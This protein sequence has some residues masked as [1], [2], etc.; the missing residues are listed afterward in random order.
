MP[1][2][3]I[4]DACNPSGR[5]ALELVAVSQAST[6]VR[7]IE[8]AGGGGVTLLRAQSSILPHMTILE[9]SFDDTAALA[10]CISNCSVVFACTPADMA[11]VIEALEYCQTETKRMQ[12]TTRLV[13]SLPDME[14]AMRELTR[15]PE[16]LSYCHFAD[17]GAEMIE[18][19]SI[20]GY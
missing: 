12:R 2:V 17:V 13:A 1:T 3:A 11:R 15:E 4:L 5:K 10:R 14:Y 20:A 8:R 7:C 16:H 6:R 19:G 18:G 9:R